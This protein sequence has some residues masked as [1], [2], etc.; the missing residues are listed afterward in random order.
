VGLLVFEFSRLYPSDFARGRDFLEVLD[1]FLGG[2]PHGWP[3][4]VEIRNANFL[5]SEYFALLARHDITHV[6][7]SWEAM[8]RWASNSRC[9]AA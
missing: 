4:G 2:L 3:Y 8:P 6:F 9:P 7:N 5:Q 1:G